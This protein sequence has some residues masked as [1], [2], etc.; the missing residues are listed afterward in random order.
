M[1]IREGLYTVE[2]R[3]PGIPPGHGVIVLNGGQALGGDG[4]FTYVGSYAANGDTLSAEIRAQRYV[5]GSSFFGK[6]EI[7]IKFSGNI[8]GPHI[9]CHGEVAPGVQLTAE[10]KLVA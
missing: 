8:D 6:D 2:F 7:E 10:L 1:T 4:L 5:P 9:F 3:S